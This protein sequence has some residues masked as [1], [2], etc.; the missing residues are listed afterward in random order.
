MA[1]GGHDRI[2]M[3]YAELA[4]LNADDRQKLAG[5][6]HAAGALED[7]VSFG[8][9]IAPGGQQRIMIE[10]RTRLGRLKNFS[11]RVPIPSQEV[12]FETWKLLVKQRLNDPQVRD[13]ELKATMLQSLSGPALENVHTYILDNSSTSKDMLD[14]LETIYDSVEDGHELLVKYFN[15]LQEPGQTAA[16]FLRV[17]YVRLTQVVLRGGIPT[18]SFTSHLNRQFSR[19]C[20]DDTLL[21]HLKLNPSQSEVDFLT[22]MSSVRAEEARSEERKKRFGDEI[23]NTLRSQVSDLKLEVKALV[24]KD[25]TQA[26]PVVKQQQSEHVQQINQVV[27][28]QQSVCQAKCSRCTTGEHTQYI[29]STRNA[30]Q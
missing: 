8:R 22:L 23:V 15:V 24:R 27:Q 10:D 16:E 21:H 19:G 3:L 5:L 11:G 14:L 29:T 18:V 9:S 7:E 25:E 13:H 6:E 4:S 28:A 17:L 1:E 26:K 2:A 20:R 30:R 12:N